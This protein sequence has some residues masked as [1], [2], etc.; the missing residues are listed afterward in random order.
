MRA[1]I[2]SKCRAS[3][4]TCRAR[5]SRR[6]RSG[7]SVSQSAAI[8][9][10]SISSRSA[11]ARR[12]VTGTAGRHRRPG[13]LAQA[14]QR[15]QELPLDVVD[16]SGRVDRRPA[17]VRR[18][19]GLMGMGEGGGGWRMAHTHTGMAV[20]RG[21]PRIGGPPIPCRRQPGML[22]GRMPLEVIL[23]DWARDPLQKLYGAYRTCYS[24]KTPGRGLERDPRRHHLPR[25][26]PRLH[27]RA[28]QDRPRLAARA[29]GLLV[30]H[31]RRVALALP[32]VRPPP[33][34]HQLRAAVAALREVQ[35]GAARVRAPEDLGQGRARRR[36][37][38]AHGRG[39]AGLLPGPR[40]RASRPRT[41]ASSSPTPRPPTSR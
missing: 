17:R 31:Q 10:V 19:F 39:D 14:R 38:P 26:D 37:R 27:H 41:P 23:I 7:S 40:R 34:R 15:P 11:A 29:G 16:E 25:E 20:R 35:G 12:S 18:P 13:L 36:V 24:P 5:P 1:A 4:P 6:S 28:A 32:P 33:H 30:R 22:S 2:S 9:A 3:S 8:S 21:A